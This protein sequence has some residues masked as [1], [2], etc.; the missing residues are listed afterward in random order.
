M[1]QFE[2]K[3][4]NTLFEILLTWEDH[5]AHLDQNDLWCDD[6]HNR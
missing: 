6:E 1:V 2:R 4:L 5:L 3:E